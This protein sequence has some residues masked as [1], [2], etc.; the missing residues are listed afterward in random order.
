MK[1]WDRFLGAAAAWWVAVVL[2]VLN[3]VVLGAFAVHFQLFGETADRADYLTAAGAHGS[4]AVLMAVAALGA[5]GLHS[6]LTAVAG[7]C[8]F[9]LLAVSSY[10]DSHRAADEG[11]TFGGLDDG[12]GGVLALPWTWL[13]VIISV[14]RT[15]HLVARRGIAA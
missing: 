10:Q 6:R 5:P 11:L 3:V 14:R 15:V 4:G 1:N 2:T 7:A 12:A 8:V 9:A 13:L